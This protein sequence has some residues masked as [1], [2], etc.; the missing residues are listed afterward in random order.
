MQPDPR[1]LEQHGAGNHTTHAHTNKHSQT[2]GIE[3]NVH[4]R[5]KLCTVCA[6][7]KTMQ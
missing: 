3:N 5:R 4:Q 7:T 6:V 2:V 1:E